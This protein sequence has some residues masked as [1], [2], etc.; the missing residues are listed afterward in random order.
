MKNK[1]EPMGYYTY[2]SHMATILTWVIYGQLCAFLCTTFLRVA[3]TDTLWIYRP[4]LCIFNL[5]KFESLQRCKTFIEMPEQYAFNILPMSGHVFVL[6]VWRMPIFHFSMIV[7]WILELLWQWGNF[8]FSLYYLH[9][10]TNYGS[11]LE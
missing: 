5:N 4:T 8:C 2:P 1:Q 11:V 10:N 6:W 9:I 7:Y 3:Q